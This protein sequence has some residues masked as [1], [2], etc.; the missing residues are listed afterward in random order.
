MTDRILVTGGAG[1]VGS[2][3]CKALAAAGYLPVTYDS[4][5]HGH[6]EAVNWGPLEVGNLH[7]TDRLSAV[8]A[9]HKPSAVLHFAGLIAAGESVVSPSTFYFNNVAGTLSLLEAMRQSGV[10]NIVFS[11]TAAV[12]GNPIAV[13]IKEE[14]PLA[15]INPY[16]HSK[17][18]VEQM[19]K[20]CASAYG[21]HAIALRYFNA[22]GADEDGEIGERH[23]P[24]THLIPLILDAAIGVRPDVAVFGRD[25]ETPDGTCVRDYV[26]V[27]DLAAAHVDALRRAA[28][29]DGF[30]VFNLG[31]GQGH[32]VAEVI[33][34]VQS[35][36]G[37]NIRLR[38]ADRRPGDPPV[39]VSDISRA[40]DVL[41]W[42]PKRSA[43]TT[44]IRDAWNW[45]RKLHATTLN[46]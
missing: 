13:P 22:C 16:G 7:D 28:H 20:D 36:V 15:P 39:L 25:Y 42:T 10:C 43:L 1:Y 21:M 34:A 46:E 18:M 14:H 24:E 45:H 27:S 33:A 6:R 31:N 29:T 17:L 4:L 2:H 37:R 8:M 5:E 41:N 35:V 9:D 19:L 38:E 11:S 12:Y 40:Q 3:A 23:D 32:S 26:H 30:D 44:Q